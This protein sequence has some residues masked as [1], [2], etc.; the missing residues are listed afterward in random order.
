VPILPNFAGIQSSIQEAW[1]LNTGSE[2]ETVEEESEYYP[3]YDE[4]HPELL[5]QTIQRHYSKHLDITLRKKRL[6]KTKKLNFKKM[7]YMGQFVSARLIKDPIGSKMNSDFLHPG[8]YRNMSRV[9]SLSEFAQSRPNKPQGWK[10][11]ID[12]AVQS[13]WVRYRYDCFRRAGKG[14]NISDEFRSL[15]S[16]LA[17]ALDVNI[18]TMGKRKKIIGG[19][20]TL[21]EFAFLTKS[22][23]SVCQRKI[24]YGAHR[25]RTKNRCVVY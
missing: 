7:D 17:S 12:G 5:H 4:L 1:L 20:L 6:W 25:N 19:L 8:L 24:K 3:D 10:E 22:D 21:P 11:I 9:N 13:E 18:S 15:V 16:E 23:V 2:A 14:V